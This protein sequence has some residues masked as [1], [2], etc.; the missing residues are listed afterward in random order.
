MDKV[1]LIFVGGDTKVDKIITSVTGG[2]YSHV[3]GFLFDSVYESTGQKEE[4]DPYP[5][6]W[7]HDA[8]KYNNNQ[9]AEFIEVDIPDIEALKIEGRKLLGTPYGYIDCL[10]GGFFDLLGIKTLDNDWAMD[11]SE[12]WTRLLRAGGLDILTNIEA[13]DITPARIRQAILDNGY[14]KIINP[15]AS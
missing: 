1:T 6:V 15:I 5:G 3:A 12:T 2:V 13:G 11:C 4:G 8:N 9:Y 7:L 14:G 10:R